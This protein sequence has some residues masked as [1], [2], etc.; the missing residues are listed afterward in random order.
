MVTVFQSFSLKRVPP[1]LREITCKVAGQLLARLLPQS[2][3]SIR[4]HSGQ[5]PCQ[6]PTKGAAPAGPG[7]GRAHPGEGAQQSLFTKPPGFFYVFKL[8]RNKVPVLESD[9]FPP[10]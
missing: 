3:P 4:T 5:G 10:P 7:L 6:G 2:P 1:A 8:L 9:R